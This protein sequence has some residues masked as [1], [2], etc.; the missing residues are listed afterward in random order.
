MCMPETICFSSNRDTQLYRRG[1]LF[2]IMSASISKLGSAPPRAGSP[3]WALALTSVAFFMVNLDALVVI[4]ALPA[5]HQQ[6]GASP[7]ALQWTVNAYT[8]AFA[9][10]IST[11]AALGDR[12]G[13]RRTYVAGLVLFTVASAACALSPTPEALIA[14]RALQGIAAGAIMPLSLTILTGAFPAE[15]RGAIIGIWGGIAGLAVAIGPLVGGAVTQG[16]TWHWIFWVNVPIGL[17]AAL[18]STMRLTES[19]G[20]ATR[21][22]PAAVVLVSGGAVGLVLGMVRAA[23]IGWSSPEALLTLGVGVVLMAGF[24]LWE[25]RTQDP[26]L[27][28]RLF[29]GRTFSAGNA[30]AFFMT[31]SLF[32]GAFL[33]TQFFQ[34][35]LGYSPLETGMRLLPWTAT[36]LVV[37]P[38]AGALSDRIGRRPLMT[39]GMLLQATGLAGFVLAAGTGVDYWPSI[40]LLVLAG[41]GIS[42]VLPVTPA[43]ILSAVAPENMGKAS[44]VQ[45]TM[46]R[47]GSAFGVAVATAVFASNGSLASSRTF[48]DGFRPA[49]A[50]LAGLAVL[51]AFSALAVVAPRA[52][53]RPQARAASAQVD[54]VPDAAA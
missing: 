42:M 5:I 8:L 33:V 53:A 7:S 16:L 52:G 10:A 31:G 54:F 47:F 46:Q 27:P 24:V 40:L 29:A 13:R 26:M 11:A 2:A 18:L 45:S 3:G 50:V 48:T 49:L 1:G 20:A 4:T 51:G 9:A 25:L 37:A 15:R 41:A 43:A 17:V 28:M 6:F 21:L 44:G 35:G 36:P 30:T 12:F 23:D 22:D 19:T 34:L 32:G 39:V 38:I 14:G